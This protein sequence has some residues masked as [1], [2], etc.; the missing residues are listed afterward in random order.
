[1]A[2]DKNMLIEIRADDNGSARVVRENTQ[3]INRL[4]SSTRS[5]SGEMVNYSKKND[6]MRLSTRRSNQALMNTGRIVQDLPYGIRGVANNIDPFILSMQRA[7]R[8]TGSYNSVL[9]GMARGLM[10]PAGIAIG[11]SALTSVIIAFG[12]QIANFFRDVFGGG[13]NKIKAAREQAELFKETMSGELD[14]ALG[15]RDTDKQIGIIQG[16]IN[17]LT[18]YDEVMKRSNRTLQE[19]LDIIT[20][21]NGAL[22][23]T[24]KFTTAAADATRTNIAGLDELLSAGRNFD[25]EVLAVLRER[26]NELK[27]TLLV[28]KELEKLG[29]SG[30][31]DGPTGIEKKLN[32]LQEQRDALIN[33]TGPLNAAQEV[34][35]QQLG[36]EIF[37]YNRMIEQ[38]KT[39][40]GYEKRR[41]E[42]LEAANKELQGAYRTMLKTARERAN[43]AGPLVGGEVIAPDTAIQEIDFELQNTELPEMP[44][45]NLWAGARGIDELTSALQRYGYSLQ[46]INGMTADFGQNLLRQEQSAEALSRGIERLAERSLVALGETLGEVL[47]GQMEGDPF[48]KFKL[49]FADFM[50]FMGKSLIA[51]GIGS[52]AFRKLFSNPLLAIGAGIALVAAASAVRA[53][54]QNK[55]NDITGGGS[56]GVVGYR[57]FDFGGNSTGNSTGSQSGGNQ[58]GPAFAAMG[59]QTGDGKREITITDGFGNVVAKGQEEIDRKGGSTYLR[60]NV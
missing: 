6:K 14:S 38:R 26:R 60:G 15:D 48:M 20:E 47:S 43:E 2:A 32:E 30:P 58:S 42:S 24:A 27:A 4:K 54:A 41:V 22:Q 39:M 50:S 19:S 45:E 56:T 53:S 57:G 51:L 23:Q 46:Q 16:A 11:I 21:R 25:R 44:Q 49:I 34:R 55:I 12:P 33:Q 1:M 29:L 37:K 52:K 13:A 35:L 40:A 36:T 17:S 59:G 7:K 18:G 8:E 9:K 5:T 3:A 10:G 31:G 28:R